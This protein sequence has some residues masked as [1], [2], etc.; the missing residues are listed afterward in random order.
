MGDSIEKNRA[1]ETFKKLTKNDMKC[2]TK[3]FVNS[4]INVGFFNLPKI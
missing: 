2:D 3:I 4:S 1:V